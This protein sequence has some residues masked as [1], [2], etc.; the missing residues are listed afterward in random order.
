MSDGS[1]PR[2]DST[3]STGT[4]GYRLGP[5]HFASGMSGLNAWT[6]LYV[7][8]MVMPIVSFLSF[9]QPYVLTE[10]VGIPAAEQ[11]RITGL[12]VTMQEIVALLLVGFVGGLSDRF[13][14]RPLYAL[15]IFVAGIGFALYANAG[16]AG[17]LFAYRFVYAIGVAFVGVMIAVTAADYPAESSRGKLA[18]VTGLLN[19]LGVGLATLLVAALPAMFMA[20][21]MSSAQ[22]GQFMLYAMAGICF[23]TA[24][25]INF[26]LKGGTPPASATGSASSRPS[27]WA[28]RSRVNPRIAS[29]TRLVHRT[30]RPDAGRHLRLAVVTAGRP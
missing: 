22:A 16:S 29:A 21:G 1:L 5:I 11:G 24:L 23:V 9:S 10:I 12:L 7:N 26:G 30:R 15:G 27:N 28:S 13:G 25:I 14:R 18:G 19:G 20:R 2:Q 17:E 3:A 4:P 6:F 8:L